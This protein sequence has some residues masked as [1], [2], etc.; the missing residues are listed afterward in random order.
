MTS[1]GALRGICGPR[2]T[3]RVLVSFF[4]SVPKA[5]R[6]SQAHQGNLTTYGEYIPK[7]FRTFFSGLGAISLGKN[8]R[9]LLL[10]L[11]ALL[12]LMTFSGCREYSNTKIDSISLHPHASGNNQ[13]ALYETELDKPL[14]VVVEGPQK[15]GLLGGKGGRKPVKGA[16]VQFIIENP[17]SGAVFSE[18]GDTEVSVPTDVA[19]VASIRLKTGITPTDI[20]IRASVVVEG[21]ETKS[22][23]LRVSSGLELVGSKLETTT[24]G[25]IEAFGVRLKDP[26]GEPAKGVLVHF[27]TTGNTEGASIVDAKVVSDDGGVAVT[28]WKLGKM[29]QAYHAI[30][31][32][33]DRR[34]NVDVSA[35]FDTRA[36]KFEAFAMNKLFMGTVLFGGLALFLFGM[37]IMSEG[38]RRMADNRLKSILQVMTRNRFRAVLVGTGITAM[39]QSSSATTVMVVGFV[40]AGLM[41]LTQAISVDLGASIGTTV[42]AQIIA[43]KLD[44]LA[45]PAIAIGLLL[46]AL[47]R[48]PGQKAFGE[49][50]LGF[51][52]LFLG[53]S[54]MSGILKPLRH[55]P[56]FVALFQTFDCTPQ[57]GGSVPF[58]PALM[59]IVIGTVATLIVQSSSATVGLVLAL[60]SQD[61]LTFYTAVPLILGDNIGTTITAI[62]ASL[63]ANREAKRAAV[64]HALSKVFGATY[65]YLLLFLPLWNGQ[66]VFLGLINAITP[67]N[68][69]ASEPENLMRHVAN[70]HTAFNIFNCM[71][72]LPLVGVMAKICRKII[73]V[74]D[75]DKE[76]ELEYLEPL[77]L[78]SPPV[79]LKQ[80]TT[81]VAYMLK[82]SQK[83]LVQACEYFHGGPNELIRKI[84]MREETID[85]LQE[86]ITD[87]LV[88]LSRKNLTPEEAALIP[89]LIHA[90]ND[91]ERIG[92]R[93][94]DLLEIGQAK[95]QNHHELCVEAEEA[96][97][98]CEEFL[99]EQFDSTHR[100][101]MEVDPSQVERCKVI[102][103][104]I[105]SFIKTVSEEHVKRIESGQSEGRAGIIFLD[106][107]SHFERISAHLVGIAERA[108]AIVQATTP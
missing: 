38:L 46:A 11:P 21:G 27:S 98:C 60:C 65:M 61:L 69:F 63:G 32:I 55:S 64:A 44:V 87:Y 104:E 67:G 108:G 71:L 92:D 56:E 95:R 81:E 88:L 62:L 107:L 82:R 29:S 43:F 97:L 58:G 102:R 31:E 91:A 2:P 1:G 22:V 79:A 90:V 99:K 50:V 54:T 25:T 66:P 15:P 52:L 12:L 47:G 16:Q 41:T 93:S 45:Y 78:D 36:F 6:G 42:T 70:S 26:S 4:E 74:T 7:M 14:R 75:A 77:L 94:E 35:R 20:N 89:A 100:A 17:G 68:A 51:G 86:E 18:T 9:I 59:C 57:P 80:A 10:I 106:S 19:G 8:A 23:G 73:P 96:M 48:R 83:S 33:E 40:N 85:R 76:T 39:I 53:M 105:V 49:A 37:K 101:L 5:V 30:V 24:G 84:L 72:F 103:K 13:C 34:E 3:L 28:S